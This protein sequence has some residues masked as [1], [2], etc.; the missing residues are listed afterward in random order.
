MR[1]AF[2]L[3]SLLL[4]L[5][6]VLFNARQSTR[7]LQLAPASSAGAA[8]PAS[9]SPGADSPRARTE[10]VREQLQGALDEAAQRASEAAAP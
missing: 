6:I 10:A 8:D 7:Q 3:V 1:A 9:S 4:V 2:G 5:G